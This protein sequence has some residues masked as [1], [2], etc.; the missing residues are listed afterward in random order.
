MASTLKTD[1]WLFMAT[2]AMASFG[3]LT[4]YSA[5]SVIAELKFHNPWHF[6]IRQSICAVIL[7][8]ALML[9]KKRRYT[10]LENS[11][12]AF[13]I[14]GF[15]IMLLVA[16]YFLD[17]AHHRWLRLGPLNLQPSELAKPA[18]CVFLAWFVS[19]RAP[20]INSRRHTIVPALLVI[21]GVVFAVG[22]ADLGTAFVMGAT[23]A[24]VFLVAG[25]EKRFCWMAV[26]MA[27]VCILGLIG[28]QPYRLK[29][30]IGWVD[31]TYQML[32]RLDRYGVIRDYT[33]SSLTTKDTSYQSEQSKIAIGTGGW[34]GVGLMQGKQKLLYLPEAH[35]DFIYAV[36][37]EEFGLIGTVGLLAGYVVIFWR[38]LRTSVLLEDDFGRYL[39]LSVTMMIVLQALINMTSVLGMM[40]TKGI[41]LPLISSGGSS[42]FST[43]ALLGMLMNVSEH[44]S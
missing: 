18:L 9:A 25:L 36:V 4:V 39:A 12:V 42:L 5:S 30:V 43:L 27:G 24:V 6:F 29:R 32:D 35:T 26:V 1:K 37:G 44:A 10:S 34:T 15:T 17:P 40:P 23:A 31:P 20:A 41:P 21:G 13:P 22:A 7:I 28:V 11:A 8:L 19:M 38:G 14:M 2:I 33:D 16:V 3:V